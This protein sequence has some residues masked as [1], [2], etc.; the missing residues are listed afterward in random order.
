MPD[1]GEPPLLR[2]GVPTFGCFN[3]LS[4]VSPEVIRLWATLLQRV[5]HAR[6]LLKAP[7]LGDPQVR[8]RLRDQFAAHGIDPDRLTF[9]GKPSQIE[10][11][12]RTAR[13]TWRSTRSRTT[14]AR[15]R[16]KRSGWASRSSHC[17]ATA[18]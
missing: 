12:P 17:P 11:S 9:L 14:A 18:G 7:S 10:H 2:R 4:K 3:H 6:L 16:P 5:P 13:W 8:A 1:P 15:R